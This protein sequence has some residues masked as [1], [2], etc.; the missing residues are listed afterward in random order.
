MVMCSNEPNLWCRKP[1][2]ATKYLVAIFFDYI[3]SLKYFN[4]EIQTKYRY[5]K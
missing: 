4:K 3:N 1:V 2:L 5:N